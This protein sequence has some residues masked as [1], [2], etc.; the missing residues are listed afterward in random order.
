MVDM[1]A[2]EF[3]GQIDDDNCYPPQGVGVIDARQPHPP[4]DCRLTARQGFGYGNDLI[5]IA[6]DPPVA[7]ADDVQF[8]DLS[9]SDIE[10]QSQSCLEQAP[11]LEPNDIA[12]VSYLGNGDYE[13]G[14]QRPISAE[15]VTTISLGE[16]HSAIYAS[17]PADVS[18]DC[19]SAPADINYVIDC[20]NH[21]RTCEDWQCDVDRSTVCG[22]PDILRTI[23]L[24]NG[25]GKYIPWNY[26][27]LKPNIC[28]GGGESA[29][30]GG[31]RSLPAVLTRAEANA[32]FMDGFVEYLTTSVTWDA[33]S[34]ADF[35]LISDA[36]TWFCVD[37]LSPNERATLADK[38]QDPSLTFA[39][40]FAEEMVPEIVNALL[41]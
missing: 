4:N 24:L 17:L 41:D 18:S 12:T 7:G 8:W 15:F 13:I 25:S 3:V 33:S 27:S 38:L 32:E 34:K 21:V 35:E 1:G 29:G 11:P 26:V 19:T 9:E 5:T 31:S 10:R 28:Q 37:N 2:Y 36:L 20:I 40:P 30:G 23:D 16:D 39:S 22:P 14:L 6:F